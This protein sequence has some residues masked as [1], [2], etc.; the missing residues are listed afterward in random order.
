VKADYFL[1]VKSTAGPGGQAP[2]V[3]NFEAEV[4]N[5]AGRTGAVVNN[6][7]VAQGPYDFIVQVE[8]DT[9]NAPA[10]GNHG[11]PPVTP[12]HAALALVAAL[13]Q[14]AAV[15]TETVPVLPAS[16]TTLKAFVGHS[17]T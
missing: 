16:D 8:I 11:G 5:A 10:L 12:Q 9:D 14:N 13:A 3:A 17:C 6:V 15:T 2:S 7:W 1:L 4:N